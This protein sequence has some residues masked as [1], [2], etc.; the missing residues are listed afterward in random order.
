MAPVKKDWIKQAPKFK[1]PKFTPAPKL[2]CFGPGQTI[3]HL[4]LQPDQPPPPATPPPPQLAQQYPATS[5]SAQVTVDR[6]FQVDK[7]KRYEG[8][9]VSFAPMEGQGFIKLKQENIAPGGIVFVAASAIRSVDR[10][11]TLERE[12]EVEF[13][14]MKWK[15]RGVVTLRATSVTMVGGGLIGVQDKEDLQREFIGGPAARFAGRL[16]FFLPHKSGGFGYVTVE[17]NIAMDLE[18]NLPHEVCVE[19][20][21]VNCGG[22]RPKR[23]DN[24]EVEFGIFKGDRA[25]YFAH[26]MTLPGTLPITDEILLN[27]VVEGDR[28]YMGMLTYWH[29][30]EHWG[31]ITIDETCV[32][33]DRLK[34]LIEKTHRTVVAPGKH[35]SV[36]RSN[37]YFSALDMAEDFCP[38]EG[39]RVYFNLFTD[40]KGVGATNVIPD[41]FETLPETE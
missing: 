29:W 36:R 32:I 4:P 21:E 22:R 7:S 27:R 30:Q 23:L 1:A 39:M 13:G 24:L 9:V 12:M 18:L 28:L 17:E 34:E 19:I 6:D 20:T 2:P 35:R 15:E 33:P 41:S 37:V 10:F 16:K 40:D 14:L 31:F 26:N 3:V 5:S 25:R 11:P 8:T 38:E